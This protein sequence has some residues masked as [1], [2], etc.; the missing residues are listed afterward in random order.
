MTE[1]GAAELSGQLGLPACDQIGFV[2]RDLDAA[3]ARMT[4]VF[5]PFERFEYG[6]MTWNYR[7]TEE[8]S[9]IVLALGRSGD[10]EIE[11][12]QWVSGATP[13]KEFLDAGREG[14]HHIRFVVDDVDRMI[15]KA[16]PVGWRPVWH[17]RFGEGLAAAYLERDEEPL[18]VEFFE[19]H[20]GRA[21]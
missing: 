2:Y 15:D 9:E 7:G 12:I 17:K 8:P 21:G 16:A 14:L 5:G 1:K 11:L 20:M 3:I 10:V 6:E 18:L 4:P 13:H 19:N